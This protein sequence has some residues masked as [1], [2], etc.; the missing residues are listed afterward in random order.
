[1]LML[2]AQ[3]KQAEE[4]DRVGKHQEALTAL[5]AAVRNNDVEAFTRLGK[6]LL[7][8]DR[9]PL[10]PKDGV[11]LLMDA[12]DKGSAE[13]PALLSV[14]LALGLYL[15]ND[16]PDWN[17]ALECL[18]VSAQRGWKAA[19]GQLR[20]LAGDREFA[21][22]HIDSYNAA[23]WRGL[24]STL[25]LAAWHVPPREQ[26][27]NESP[28]ICSYPQF[29]PPAVCDWLIAKA[30]PRL[31]PAEVY[32][33]LTHQTKQHETRTNSSAVFSLT[34]TDL[35]SVLVQAR[36]AAC[37]TTPVRNFEAATVLHYAPGQQITEHFDFIDPNVPD[38][39]QQIAQAGQR[40]ITF[41][42]YL[43][44][45]YED[46]ETEFP[47]VGVSHKGVR[48][49]GLFFVNALPDGSADLRTLHAGRPPRVGE[50]WIVSQFIRSR[51]FF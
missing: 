32:D 9:A 41:L 31:R 6:R 48:G 11:G 49:E 39:A 7:V 33:A 37:V 13:A 4:F 30:W 15:N 3:V 28:L 47:N 22:H 10:S 27:L 20:T 36:M 40:F 43:N 12:A 26:V 18:V 14:L 44:D 23:S 21:G 1:M 19:Q 38:H 24:A 25:D 5:T 45:Y 46:G 8:G 50:K 42:V 51:R 29:I 34:D 16:K 2:S 35:V 17:A